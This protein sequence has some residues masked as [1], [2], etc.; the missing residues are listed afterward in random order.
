MTEKTSSVGQLYKVLS[1][2]YKYRT[3]RATLSAWSK[4][5]NAEKASEQKVSEKL[6][7]LFALFHDARKDI[8]QL[9]PPYK[10]I[11]IATIS[12]LQYY[13]IKHG[14]NTTW[15]PLL[16]KLNQTT[17]RNL[18]IYDQLLIER[19]EYQEIL[20][21]EKPKELLEQVENLIQELYESNLPDKFKA[22]LIRELN[23]IRMALITFDITGECHLQ[24]ICYEVQASIVNKASRQP[25]LFKEFKQ[26]VQKVV[27]TAVTIGGLMTTYDL[28]I[29]YQPML[30]E[31]IMNLI[32]N[33]ADE[34]NNNDP[35][36]LEA[37][38]EP[39]KMNAKI[40]N[41]L[42]RKR[43]LSGKEEE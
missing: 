10:E 42:S 29:K 20:S 8:L 22:D 1:K 27:S 19:G 17:L 33:I 31:N 37:A 30:T 6:A 39:Q 34:I 32:E 9:D 14:L 13:I 43:L 35:L 23:K 25:T 21:K 16:E 24:K 38:S 26:S 40:E 3:E 4:I 11:A 5:L 7:E 36:T 41:K 28:S 15:K 18:K 2:V 12:E